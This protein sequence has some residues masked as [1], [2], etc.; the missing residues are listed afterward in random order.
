[1]HASIDRPTSDALTAQARELERLREQC[2]V[3]RAALQRVRAQLAL[4]ES[5]LDASASDLPREANERLVDLLIERADAAMYRR[6][7]VGAVLPRRHGSAE[8]VESAA[9]AGPA[10][11][12]DVNERLVIA[13][14]NARDSQEAAEEAFSVQRTNLA[15]TAHELRNPLAPIS[16]AI[17]LLKSVQTREPMAL[18]VQDIL[19]RQLAQMTRLVNDLLDASRASTGKL[20]IAHAVIDLHPLIEAAAQAFLPAMQERRQTM[21]LDVIEQP[22][23]V[24]GDT[25][26][27]LQVLSNLLD[28]ASK[29]TPEGG[30]IRL[31]MTGDATQF[32]VT[33]SDNGIG[34]S[35]AALPDVFNAFV[36]VRQVAQANGEGLGIGL[37]LVRQLVEAHGGSAVVHSRGRD[38]GSEFV[39]TLPRVQASPADD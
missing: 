1:M 26:R 21:V 34:I 23:L 38:R 9:S 12:R 27:L 31:A 4:A 7:R 33:V 36:Q 24:R 28:N 20:Q 17:R 39:V 13:V 14:L 22:A 30:S 2:T 16:Y 18:Q 15:V 35:A 37:M 11:L 25:V 32:V 29:Y 8:S 5:Q 19:E 10:R 6:K 3:A